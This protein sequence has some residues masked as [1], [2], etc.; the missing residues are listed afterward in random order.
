MY[1]IT[2][3]PQIVAHRGFSGRYPE[4]TRIAIEGAI[5]LGV[6]MVE[7]DV[8]LSRDRIPV[9]FHDAKLG[10]NTP[11][12]HR[13]DELTA[14]ELKMLDI[15]LWRGD[16]FL[17]ERILTLDEALDLVHRRIP[18]NLDIKTSAAIGSVV[19]AVRER[20]M[21]DDVVLSGCSWAQA[22]RVRQLE[23][24][25]HVLMNVDGLL[26]T[27]LRLCSARLALLIS[28]LQVR[29]TKVTGLNVGHRMAADHFIRSA[30]ARNL[31]VWTWTVDDPT[32]ALQLVKLGAISIT[33]NWPDRILATL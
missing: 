21:I 3:T 4:N 33:S 15:G 17:N 27:L 12:P 11:C 24:H 20:K 2:R 10:H 23:P 16:E 9:I 14:S 25:L 32:R 7:I 22:R 29:I 5:A 18:I 13:V 19:A 31:P 8:R 28:R 6:D 30:A 26:G 1:Q